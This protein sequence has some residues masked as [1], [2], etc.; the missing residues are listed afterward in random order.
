MAEASMSD[1]LAVYLSFYGAL[2]A[3]VR[4][5]IIVAILGGLWI[6]LR[7]TRLD[8][9]VRVRTWLAVAVPLGLWLAVIWNFATGG[10]FEPRPGGLP[11]VPI[12]VVLP[13]FIGL[14]ALTRSQSI[15]AA[16]D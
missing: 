13:V 14:F 6:A 11:L 12:A 7:R 16:V 9:G 3:V 8:A 2:I 15:A 10:A 4:P 5:A 1:S